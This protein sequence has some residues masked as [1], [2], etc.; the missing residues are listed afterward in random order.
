MYVGCLRLTLLL[1]ENDTLKGKRAVVQRVLERTRHRFPVAT[2]EIGALDD[3][4]TAVLG[5]VCTSNDAVVVDRLLKKALNFI[6]GL[7][8][9]AEIEDVELTVVRPFE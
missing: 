8:V 1:P 5:V 3:V 2:A 9:A 4:R 7:Q 6:E